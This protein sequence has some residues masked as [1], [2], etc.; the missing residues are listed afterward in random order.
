VSGA[1]AGV[2]VD[3][4]F[5]EGAEP[6]VMGRACYL[7]LCAEAFFKEAFDYTNSVIGDGTGAGFGVIVQL[8]R[9]FNG[10]GVDLGDEAINGGKVVSWGRGWESVVEKWWGVER[11]GGPE[12]VDHPK[13]EKTVCGGRV[14]SQC[15]GS[16][17]SPVRER[18]CS[19]S[20]VAS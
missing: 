2:D 10:N 13:G 5:G 3:E 20:S 14:C 7:E 9:V 11:G 18:V 8:E 12:W 16:L 19:L 4:D 6:Y 17:V 15:S 1:Y